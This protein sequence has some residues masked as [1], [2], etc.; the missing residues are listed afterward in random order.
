[1]KRIL[2]FAL[3]FGLLYFVIAHSYFVVKT[4]LMIGVVAVIALF[5]VFSIRTKGRR[6]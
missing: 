1:M 5:V 2:G 4:S 6:Q 3:I